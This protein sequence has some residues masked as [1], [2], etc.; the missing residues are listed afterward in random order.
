MTGSGWIMGLMW[1]WPVFIVAGLLTGFVV[2]RLIQEG[3]TSPPAP[4]SVGSAARRI[5]DERQA[6]GEIDEDEYRRRRSLLP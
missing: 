4:R 1:S 3:L 2:V 6:R 5:L